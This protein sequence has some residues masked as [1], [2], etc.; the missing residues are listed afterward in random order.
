[1]EIGICCGRWVVDPF[2]GYGDKRRSCGLNDR[3]VT[4][5]VTVFAGLP[6]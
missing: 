5:N 6:R 4:I 1:M 2:L 3:H